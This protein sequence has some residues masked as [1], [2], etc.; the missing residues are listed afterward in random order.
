MHKLPASLTL[1]A[2]AASALAFALLPAVAAAEAPRKLYVGIRAEAKKRDITVGRDIRHGV[3]SPSGKMVRPKAR[4]FARRYRTI[5]ARFPSQQP[6][7]SQ[8][9]RWRG[10]TNAHLQRIKQC[11]SGDDYRAISP[12]GQY[13]GA[14]Q[15]DYGTWASVGGSGDPAAASP[16]EQDMRAQMLYDRRGS[17]PWP[18]CQYR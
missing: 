13:R 10:G 6:Q 4:H 18:V 12:D 15:F 7:P 2:F 5:K 11:E 3:R 16:A 9:T 8:E 1:A 17:A 14:Y